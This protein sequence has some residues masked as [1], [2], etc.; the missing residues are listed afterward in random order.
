MAVRSSA[1]GEDG[2]TASF[3]GQHEAVLNLECAYDA[4]RRLS[5]LQCRP[6]TTLANSAGW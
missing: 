4:E 6:I 1:I 2:L 3:A 5:L